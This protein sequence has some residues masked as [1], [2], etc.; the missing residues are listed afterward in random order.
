L[1]I[2]SLFGDG[3]SQATPAR[4]PIRHGGQQKKAISQE[5]V[6]RNA[7]WIAVCPVETDSSCLGSTGDIEAA[8]NLSNRV[9]I[10]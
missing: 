6:D 8:I 4:V 3:L 1:A 5:F 9:E 7:L 2:L 10:L